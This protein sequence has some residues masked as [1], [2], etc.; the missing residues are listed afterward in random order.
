MKSAKRL[1]LEKDMTFRQ[2][3]IIGLNYV[4]AKEAKTAS[5]RR[6]TVPPIRSPS[7]P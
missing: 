1:A 4:I 3:I 6:L 2:L 7:W 5:S